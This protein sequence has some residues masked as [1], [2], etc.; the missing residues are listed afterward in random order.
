MRFLRIG[1]IPLNVMDQRESQNR[2]RV[3][4]IA[5]GDLWAGA[6]VQLTALLEALAHDPTWEL[7]AIVLNGGRLAHEIQKIGIPVTVLS[8]KRYNSLALFV[9][10]VTQLRRQRPTILHT[11]KYKDN[12][13]GACAAAAVSIPAVVRV[14]HGMP[15]PFSGI[16]YVKMKVYEFV[17]HLITTAKVSKLIAVSSNIE[18][19]LRK[20]YGA[21][22]VVKIHNGINIEK[23]R[24]S[25]D[26]ERVRD[27]LG[28]GPND[29]AIGT[30]GRLT[31]VKGHELLLRAVASL[32]NKIPNITVVIV[33]DGP[34]MPEL[35]QLAHELGMEKKV[36]FVGQRYDVYDL[37]NSMDVFALPSIHEG[38]PMGLLEAMA[39]RRAVV[40]SRVGGIPEVIDH[41]VNGLL[42][43]PGN[44]T[45]LAQGLEQIITDRTLAIQL[46]QA[47]AARIEAEF[48]A[49]VM[50]ERTGRLYASLVSQVSEK[51]RGVS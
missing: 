40:A 2:I 42:V 1:S 46:G 13:L 33:G 20:L 32:M 38:I 31:P 49:T 36:V 44:V 9:R 29:Y 27:G 24:V 23:V 48:S 43:A 4:H 12:I 5:H 14:V 19:T 35:K 51:V 15:E 34:L 50:A 22:K 16:T 25:Q 17:D 7:S 30:V 28:S 8:E 45:Q 3:C 37:V 41:G 26:R 39:L 6:E 47:G 10:I 18:T 11:H 21:C